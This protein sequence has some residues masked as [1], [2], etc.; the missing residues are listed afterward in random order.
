[1]NPERPVPAK[2]I[3]GDGSGGPPE[4]DE[5][6][7]LITEHERD[8]EASGMQYEGVFGQFPIKILEA[9]EPARRNGPPPL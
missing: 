5:F 8:L 1:M 2:T 6:V 3:M 4:T 7:V 9:P